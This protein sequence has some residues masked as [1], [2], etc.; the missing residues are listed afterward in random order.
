MF[1]S[2]EFTEGRLLN[3]L[4]GLALDPDQRKSVPVLL[5]SQID[6]RR[7]KADAIQTGARTG[8]ALPGSFAIIR[9]AITAAAFN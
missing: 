9:I 5:V 4:T 1:G 7:P 8:R 3:Q 2:K 6:A